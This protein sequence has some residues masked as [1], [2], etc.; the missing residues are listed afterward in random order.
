MQMIIPD[1]AEIVFHKIKYDS[2]VIKRKVDII[3]SNILRFTGCKK[4]MIYL[5]RSPEIIYSMVSIFRLGYTFIPVSINTPK[6][7][8]E[9]ILKNSEVELV[10]T[11]S[12]YKN[13]F[14]N[15]N[16]ICI[17]D[18]D[19]IESFYNFPQIDPNDISYIIYTSGSTGTP[20]GVE[21]SYESLL[22]FMEGLN[23]S[24]EFRTYTSIAFFTDISFDISIVESLISIINGLKIIISDEKE[25]R[26]PRLMANLIKENEISV[27]QM[28]PSRLLLLQEIDKS[29]SCLKSL[30][31]IMVGGEPFPKKLLIDLQKYTNAHI[32]NMYGPTEATVWASVSNLTNKKNID[33][34]TPIL[35]TKFYILDE[36]LNQMNDGEIGEIV[37]SGKC[38][39]NKY[40]NNKLLTKE[41]F[42]YSKF[43]PNERMYKTGDLGKCSNGVYECLGRNDNQIKL[44]GYRIELE[45]IEKVAAL[46][47]SIIRTMAF[48]HNNILILLYKS[49]SEIN[50]LNLKNF[51]KD[52]LNEYMIPSKILK[53]DDFIYN[54]AGKIDRKL[55]E[56][57]LHK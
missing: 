5:D 9:Y 37:I 21:I 22:N 52:T 1:N 2:S 56:N 27:L 55:S 19:K 36:N 6:K 38:L 42:V 54:N 25:Q 39:A 32:Y 26:N 47:P 41:K 28:T 57:L 31:M 29:F 48:L 30:K 7:R 15:Y 51:L 33:I 20:K 50:E 16:V 35:N 34:G 49:D 45:E 44:N 4:I 46:Y 13:I 40:T 43:Y 17:E 12:K 14:D 10:I 53:V 23:S 8:I 18:I 3:M 11:N 24:V